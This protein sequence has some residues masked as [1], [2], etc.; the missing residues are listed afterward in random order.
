[1]LRNAVLVGLSIANGWLLTT[2]IRV[3]SFCGAPSRRARMPRSVCQQ[4]VVDG[5]PRVMLDGGCPA[6]FRSA[7]D[8]AMISE[9]LEVEV[10]ESAASPRCLRALRLLAEQCCRGIDYKTLGLNWNH[11]SSR[12][13]YRH[14]THESF[15]AKSSV[16]RSKASREELSRLV[17]V[18]ELPSSQTSLVAV[19]LREI[20]SEPSDGHAEVAR[21]EA[22]LAA[23]EAEL[24]L[25]LRAMNEGTKDLCT[26]FT[27]QSIPPGLLTKAVVDIVSHVVQG[28]FAEWRYSNPVG[29]RQ[30]EGLSHD[31]IALWSEPM[32]T[33]HGGGLIVHEDAPGELGLFWATKIGGPSHGFDYEGQCLLPLLANARHKVVLVSDPAW[34]DHPSGRAHLR[35]LW[36]QTMPQLPVMWLEALNQ[37]YYARVDPKPWQLAVLSHLVQKADAMG[38][39]LSVAPFLQSSLQVLVGENGGKVTMTNDRIVLRPSN[40]GLEASDTLSGKH[41]WVQTTE[42]MTSAISRC[43]YTPAGA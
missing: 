34:P 27:G 3:A 24:L 8:A 31:Q 20:G 13:E 26:T 15:R 28:D 41:D 2:H 40:A 4:H 37:D 42:E 6:G 25:P 29:R 14:G 33:E 5:S 32:W 39:R 21:F 35:L 7:E 30:L 43:T 1:M 16:S 10:Q 11:P 38:I 12:S 22:I 23:L 18:G 17:R 19:F 36:T 9:F